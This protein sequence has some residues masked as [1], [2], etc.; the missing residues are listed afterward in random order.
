[1]SEQHPLWELRIERDVQSLM[2]TISRDRYNDRRIER[3]LRETLTK[4]WRDVE[5]RTE[6]EVNDPLSITGL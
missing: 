3:D 4:L 5:A 6:P 2:E 1:M